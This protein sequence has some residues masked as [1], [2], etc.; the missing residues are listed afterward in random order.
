M[1]R[2]LESIEQHLERVRTIAAAPIPDAGAG[3]DHKHHE[4]ALIAMFEAAEA[5]GVELVALDVNLTD[6]LN[7]YLEPLVDELHWGLLASF[8][9]QLDAQARRQLID[10]TVA[11]K[12]GLSSFATHASPSQA[13]RLWLEHLTEQ[14]NATKHAWYPWQVVSRYCQR[15]GLVTSPPERPR[16]RMPGYTWL[17][18]RGLDRLRWLMALE[19]TQAVGD[20]DPWCASAAQLTGIIRN[21]GRYFDDDEDRSGVPEW[22]GVER[23]TALGVLVGA[24]DE[25][26]GS[27]Y[28]LTNSGEQLL[29][30]EDP[31]IRELFQNLARAQAHD[32]RSEALGSGGP[33]AQS[34]E[35]AATTMRHARLVA[36]EVRNALLPVRHALDKVWKSIDNTDTGEALREPRNQIEQGITRLY[37]FVEAS[38]RMSAPVT[39]LPT[40]FV[41]IEA[42]EEARLSLPELSGVQISTIP[43][44]ANPRFRGHR[45]HFV[46]ALLNVM[47]NAIQVAGPRVALAITVDASDAA[48]I[49]I[50]IDDNGPGIPETVRERL[51]ENGAS[52]RAD[53]TGHGLAL[54]REVVERELGGTISYEPAPSGGARFRLGLPSLQ[55]P[56]G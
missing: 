20:D 4:A 19:A 50:T 25:E 3:P 16:L 6:W 52:S 35:L 11:R 28:R 43:G 48:M 36:H 12:S 55:E 8:G 23:W 10:W 24:W 5:S 44:T 34:S 14:N 1:T 38:A 32:D 46:L 30:R 9:A 22:S 13:M 2:M 21:V 54:V 49:A 17:R 47:R 42:I 27:S 7:R 45:G 56:N 51:F 40:T 37:Q 41:V 39:E 53:G 15:L 31:D 26:F 18:L 29:S 33:I